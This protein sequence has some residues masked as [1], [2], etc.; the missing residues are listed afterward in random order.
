MSEALV[1][2]LIAAVGPIGAA[3][4]GLA[5]FLYRWWGSRERREGGEKAYEKAIQILKGR[6][7]RA[8]DP[9]ERAE[10]EQQLRGVEDDY[11]PYLQKKAASISKRVRGELAPAGA[12][13]PDMPALSPSDREALERAAATIADLDPPKT[14]EDYLSQG[15][16]FYAAGQLDKALEQYSHALE[17]KPDDP[18]TLRNRGAVLANLQ[19]YDEALADF[20]RSR[21]PEPHDP[22]TLIFR[23]ATLLKLERYDEAL[24]DIN[25]ALELR[26]G[27]PSALYNRA[28]TYS[29]IGRLQDSLNDLKEAI[30]RYEIYRMIA[31]EDEDFNNLRSDPALGPE[32]EALVAEPKE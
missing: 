14:A 29:V 17:L 25:R 13:T 2:A 19:R 21:E 10:I 5:T 8:E 23:G 24:A 1:I 16:A 26:P 22:D 27:Y 12:I 30:S 15:Y 28:C 11:L 6:F 4:V 31:R 18:V 3:T 32:F 20:N 7:E 9:A